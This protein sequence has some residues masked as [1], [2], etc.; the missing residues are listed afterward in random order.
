MVTGTK[1]FFLALLLQRL[2]YCEGVFN[3]LN[4]PVLRR[5]RLPFNRTKQ[6]KTK[7]C[8]GGE[9]S[10]ASAGQAQ[11]DTGGGTPGRRV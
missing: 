1:I 8:A 7:S 3:D 9:R 11:L 6:T 10:A 5:Q 4:V 2:D